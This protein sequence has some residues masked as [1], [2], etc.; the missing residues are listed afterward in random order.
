MCPTYRLLIGVAGR[1]NAFAI[2]E[3]IGVPSEI[4]NDAKKRVD[5]G[6]ADFEAALGT[7]QTERA[8]AERDREEAERL[9]KS[10]MEHEKEAQELRAEA[11]SKRDKAEQLA[12]R[13]A[14]AVAERDRTLSLPEHKLL[15][16]RIREMFNVSENGNS[17]N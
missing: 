15:R 10:A 2:S 8:E 4:I 1:S 13:E 16:E 12:K 6:N 17:F 7:L 11:A 14:I 9:L 3:R 5:S